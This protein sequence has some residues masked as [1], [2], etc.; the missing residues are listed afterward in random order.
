MAQPFA[1]SLSVPL[2]AA[3]LVAAILCS[4]CCYMRYRRVVTSRIS[5]A[6]FTLN[7]TPKDNASGRQESQTEDQKIQLNQPTLIAF[8]NA[9]PHPAEQNITVKIP[10]RPSLFTDS[11]AICIMNNDMPPKSAVSVVSPAAYAALVQSPPPAR[12][13]AKGGIPRQDSQPPMLED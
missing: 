10:S 7:P 12:K 11:S 5:E 3:I 8:I 1:P 4:V 13:T 2:I 6:T 9:Q